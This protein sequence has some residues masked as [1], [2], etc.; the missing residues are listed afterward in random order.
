MHRIYTLV[1]HPFPVCS[2]AVSFIVSS[3]SISNYFNFS[4]SLITALPSFLSHRLLSPTQ[5][6]LLT[7]IYLPAY[8]LVDAISSLLPS[9]FFPTRLLSLPSLFALSCL[10]SLP[11]FLAF[12]VFWSFRILVF[13]FPKGDTERTRCPCRH[14]QFGQWTQLY[15]VG[16]KLQLKDVAE[17]RV[18]IY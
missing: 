7:S 9:L 11:F 1:I 2:S 10:L 12:L 8:P 4:T 3:S 17:V 13:L 15:G 16:W 18:V 14:P 6:S 5:P